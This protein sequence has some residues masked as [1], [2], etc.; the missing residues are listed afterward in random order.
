MQEGLQCP[1][2]EVTSHAVLALQNRALIMIISPGK[3]QPWHTSF[4]RVSFT[5]LKNSVN[6]T[7]WRL[8]HPI[9]LPDRNSGPLLYFGRR[10]IRTHETRMRHSCTFKSN[11]FVFTTKDNITLHI[12]QG[13]DSTTSTS[14]HANY[15]GHFAAGLGPFHS[16]KQK[17]Q[18]YRFFF[19]VPLQ[20]EQLGF[21]CNGNF[22]TSN[23][24]LKQWC[25]HILDNVI[26]APVAKSFP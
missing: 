3:F 15:L 11:T 8:S 6:R 14:F 21:L 1:L 17:V 5:K 25:C 2:F 16:T 12:S 26:T 24:L 22:Q 20:P 23:P 13:H 7:D 19:L 18:W 4:C 9:F 10:K